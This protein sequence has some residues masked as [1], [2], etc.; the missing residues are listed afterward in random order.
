[1]VVGFAAEDGHGAVELLDEQEADH[2]VTERHLAE[3]YLR[4][5]ALIDRLTEPIRPADDERQSACGCVEPGL[6]LVG[7]RQAAVLTTMFV[8]QDNETAFHS[9]Q[10]GF[11]FLLLLLCLGQALRVLEV[12]N[13][14]NIKGYVVLEAP[15]VRLNH[16]RQFIAGRFAYYKQ[17]CLHKLR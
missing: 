8:Q 13:D 12:G 3:T 10:N 4:V 16:L 11:T 7:K 6:Q 14:Q 9:P 17:G 5:C 15:D 1:M 2:L